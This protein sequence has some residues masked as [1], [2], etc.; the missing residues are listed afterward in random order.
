MSHIINDALKLLRVL[1]FTISHSK[2][3]HTDT[4]YSIGLEYNIPALFS[5]VISAFY[6]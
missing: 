2:L 6:G 4:T 5:Y 3:F 1:K